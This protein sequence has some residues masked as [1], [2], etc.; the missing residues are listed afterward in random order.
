MAG[1]MGIALT[2]GANLGGGALAATFAGT[3]LTGGLAVAQTPATGLGEAAGF[4]LIC[5]K[6]N[7]LMS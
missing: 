6:P 2:G 4:L 7:W 5:F 1:L 3:A